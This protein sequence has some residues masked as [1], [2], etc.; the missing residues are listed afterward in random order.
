MS[1]FYV[2]LICQHDYNHICKSLDVAGNAKPIK[3]N[4]PVLKF[5]EFVPA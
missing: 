4:I 5:S 1:Q 3:Q 2:T